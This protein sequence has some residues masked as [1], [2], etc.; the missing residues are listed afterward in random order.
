[1]A[2]VLKAAE[3]L[4]RATQEADSTGEVTSTASSR[5]YDSLRQLINLGPQQ[6]EDGDLSS[7]A[8]FL[9]LLGDLTASG[10]EDARF[11]S[12]DGLQCIAGR[13]LLASETLQALRVQRRFKR[14][15]ATGVG[16]PTPED[17][18]AALEHVLEVRDVMSRT[19]NDMDSEDDQSSDESSDNADNDETLVDDG[20]EEENETLWAACDECDKWRVVNPEQHKALQAGGD[21]AVFHCSDTGKACDDRQLDDVEGAE[22]FLDMLSRAKNK[23]K[24]ES[25]GSSSKKQ[26]SQKHRQKVA[27][28]RKRRAADK[29]RQEAAQVYRK[30]K[31]LLGASVSLLPSS[32]SAQTMRLAPDVKLN[33]VFDVRRSEEARAIAAFD[34]LTS[35]ALGTFSHGWMWFEPWG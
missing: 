22:L 5:L 35:T 24:N 21:A 13:L 6:D 20:D 30:L 11:H 25:P 28:R 1:M 4:G 19:L 2:Q 18:F 29:Q 33:G 31:Q 27:K 10:P 15:D 23:A 17:C 12:A 7:P 34:H 32:S 8:S 14:V 26:L 16:M 3:V 9:S